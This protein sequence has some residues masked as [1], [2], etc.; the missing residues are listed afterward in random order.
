MSKKSV[1]IIGGGPAGLVSLKS[2]LQS[3]HLTGTLFEQKDDVGGL[4]HYKQGEKV[5]QVSKKILKGEIVENGVNE[6]PECTTTM[7]DDLT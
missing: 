4:W 3:D 5:F 1:C 2:V 6:N 7:Y